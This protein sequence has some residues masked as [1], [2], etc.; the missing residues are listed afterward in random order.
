MKF[1]RLAALLLTCPSFSFGV[2]KDLVQMQRDLEAKIDAMQM[3]LNSK[4]DTLAGTLTAMQ[5]DTRRTAEQVATLQESMTNSLAKSLT[6]VAGLSGRVDSVGDEVR[7]LKDS[8][9]ELNTRLERMDAKLTDMKNQIQIIQSP[10]AA[11]PPADSNATPPPGSATQ[12]P[13]PQSGLLPGQT[14]SSGAA[15]PAMPPRGMSAEASYTAAM[16]DMQTG[17]TDL[18]YTEFQQFLTYFPNTE[19]AA[20]AQYYLGEIDYKRGDY[21]SAIK[22]FDVVLERYPENPKTADAHLMKA[23]ALLKSNQRGRAVQEFRILVA[24]YPRTE[25]ARQALQQLRSL[26]VSAGTATSHR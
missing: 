9:A 18:A 26:G 12:G 6:P 13:Y 20:K 25:D 21:N 3:G 5:N 4:L 8:L 15:G 19:L 17:K 24:N 10:P 22:G 1:L 11:P 23:Q 2:N 14:L 16:R 7:S